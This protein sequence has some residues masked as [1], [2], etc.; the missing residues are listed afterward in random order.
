MLHR[1]GICYYESNRGHNI[2]R[3]EKRFHSV[4]QR[5]CKFCSQWYR[6]KFDYYIHVYEAHEDK[7]RIAPHLFELCWGIRKMKKEPEMPPTPPSSPDDLSAPTTQSPSSTTLKDEYPWLPAHSWLF[8]DPRTLPIK[9]RLSRKFHLRNGLALAR[10]LAINDKTAG[11]I[12][13][14]MA[15]AKNFN[16]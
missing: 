2:K 11:P 3:H 12:D 14:S 1:C 15:K 13:Y 8:R 7:C 4:K 16:A 9:K 10:P 6:T 5:L